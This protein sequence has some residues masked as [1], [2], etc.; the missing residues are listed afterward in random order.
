MSSHS[1]LT[2]PVLGVV[3]GELVQGRL[4]FAEQ[5][6]GRG[7]ERVMGVALLS[8]LC[9]LSSRA[10]QLSPGCV[11]LSQ[12]PSGLQPLSEPPPH[13]THV[14]PPGPASSPRGIPLLFPGPL[15]QSKAPPSTEGSDVGSVSI[16]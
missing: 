8:S 3:V 13:H 15:A 14:L 9:V 4:A 11:H 2:L 5:Q 6:A 16:L 7:G 1:F 12:R 10:S